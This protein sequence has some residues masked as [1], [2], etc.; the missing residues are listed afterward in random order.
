MATHPLRVLCVLMENRCRANPLQS[1]L[2]Y[3]NP[4][5]RFQARKASAKGLTWTS[6]HGQFLP[7]FIFNQSP[8]SGCLCSLGGEK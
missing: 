5:Y 7:L 4:H 6:P 2:T 3:R 8:D 1:H